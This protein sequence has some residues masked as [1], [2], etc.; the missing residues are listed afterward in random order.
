[1]AET[2]KLP[3]KKERAAPV[4][5]SWQPLERMRREMDRLFDEL[6][7][8]FGTPARW[9]MPEMEPFWR[10][11]ERGMT[12][13]ADMVERP[14]RYEVTAELPG[15]DEKNI[16]VKVVNGNLTISGEKKEEKEEKEANYYMSE[17]RYGSFQRSFRLPEGVNTDKIEAA[18]KNG[19]LT[20]ALP[21][22]E[23][24]K[25]ETKIGIKAA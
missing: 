14:D 3:V 17:R 13:V 8:G 24:A 10:A 18:F 25:K 22:T 9:S 5:T 19:V 2:T 12:P 1:M 7:R 23:E 20:V 4:E 16:E 11:S 21:K 15:M 6:G